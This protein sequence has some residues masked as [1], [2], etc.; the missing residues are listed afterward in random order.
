MRIA[1]DF[2]ETFTRDPALWTEFVRHAKERGHD[3]RFVT[4]R[5][6]TEG[7]D[8]EAYADRSCI[9]IIYTSRAQKRAF[10]A[11]QDFRP[12]V[13]IDDS[14]EFIVDLEAMGLAWLSGK[15]A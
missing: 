9:P 12:H 2:D 6:P 7:E 4:M 15:A 13:W 14:P 11:A 1:L 10:C 3:V 8:I 5:Y